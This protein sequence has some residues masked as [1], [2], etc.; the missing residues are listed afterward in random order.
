MDLAVPALAGLAADP[1]VSL[2]D[3]AF[4]GQLGDAQLGALGVNGSLF[5]MTF[6]IF[7]FIAYGT[8]PRVGPET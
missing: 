7:N 8:T 2:V 4:V 5:A 6:V 1:L 3:T